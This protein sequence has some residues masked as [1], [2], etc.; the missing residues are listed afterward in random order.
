MV[1]DFPP[2]GLFPIFVIPTA[3]IIFA[4]GHFFPKYRNAIEWVVLLAALIL[5]DHLG[6]MKY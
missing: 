4:L 5:M 2:D 3:A 1:R 6:K